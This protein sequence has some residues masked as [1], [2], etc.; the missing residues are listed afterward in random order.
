[1]FW[2]L[3]NT[4]ASEETLP[5]HVS[6][7]LPLPAD[8]AKWILE[9]N[10]KEVPVDPGAEATTPTC[11]EGSGDGEDPGGRVSGRPLLEAKGI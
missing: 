8:L 10:R 11:G 1:M 2:V 7:A 5:Q 3:G 4:W 6:T 9:K